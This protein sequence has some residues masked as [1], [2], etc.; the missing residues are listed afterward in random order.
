MRSAKIVWKIVGTKVNRL[1]NR[2]RLG[3]CLEYPSI[4]FKIPCVFPV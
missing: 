1:R 2:F 4:V 3:R